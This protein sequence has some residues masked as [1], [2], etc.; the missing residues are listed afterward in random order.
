MKLRLLFANLYQGMH[1]AGEAD[2]QDVFFGYKPTL[3]GDFIETIDPQLACFVEFPYEGESGGGMLQDRLSK[4]LGL[5][6]NYSYIAGQSWIVEG[7]YYGNA[8][9]SKIPIINYLQTNLLNPKLKKTWSDGTIW[10]MHDKAVQQAT[11]VVDGEKIRLF[12]LHYFPFRKFGRSLAEEEFKPNRQ[13]LLDLI[14]PQENEHVIVTGD[15]NNQGIPIEEAFPELFERGLFT[16]ALK[17][18]RRNVDSYYSGDG[19]QIDH[20]LHTAG[21]KVTSAETLTGYSDHAS[22]VVDFEI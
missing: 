8:I 1:F 6:H 10:T 11:I 14:H 22:L 9:F 21:L 17:Y 5:K 16:T 12:N 20:V 15:F 18:D 19:I 4:D 7:N 3:Y 2:D 13:S